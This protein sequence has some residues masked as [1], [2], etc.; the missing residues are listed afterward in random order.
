MRDVNW[1]LD[2]TDVE[3]SYGARAGTIVVKRGGLAQVQAGCQCLTGITLRSS[4]SL[5]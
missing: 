3:A 5:L 2:S 4:W 1:G